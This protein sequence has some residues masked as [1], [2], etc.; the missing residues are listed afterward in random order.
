[1]RARPLLPCVCTVLTALLVATGCG[2][3]AGRE[4]LVLTGS[5]TVA[6]LAAEIA[7]RFEEM[8]PGTRVD[9][10]TGGSSRGIQDARQGQADLGMV[11]RSLRPDEDDL[12]G[13]AIAR[14]GICMIVHRDNPVGEL[15]RDQIVSIY[16]GRTRNWSEVGG[17]DAAITVVTKAAGRSTLELFVEHFELDRRAIKPDVVI[18]DNEQGIKTVAGNADAIGYVSIGTAS[19]DAGRGVPLRLLP[20]GGVPA[21]LESVGAGTFPLARDLSLVTKGSPSALA[22]RFIDFARSAQVHDIVEAQ[23]FV[24]VAN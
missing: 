1:M 5:S 2:G 12:R 24:P 23:C 20:V 10:Q 8:N 4:T 14:D 15:S 13:F 3:D 19:Y 9:V 21:T 7:K 16:T 18:G 22:Q 17:R 11:S 6:P